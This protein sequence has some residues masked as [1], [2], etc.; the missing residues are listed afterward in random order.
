MEYYN[1][2][3]SELKYE[4]NLYL[5][6]QEKLNWS[7]MVTYKNIWYECLGEKGINWKDGTICKI[8]LNECSNI[9]L[10]RLNL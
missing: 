10:N 9:N 1:V 2:S 5:K 8:R 3:Y 4:L 6:G 7:T